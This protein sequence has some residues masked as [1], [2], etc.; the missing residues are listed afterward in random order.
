MVEHA[1][2]LKQQRHD[3]RHQLTAINELAGTDNERLKEY[4]HSLIETIPPSQKSYCDNTAVNAIVS[5]FASICEQSGIE[6]S[7]NLTVPEHNEQ[8]TDS[9]LCVIFGNL[10]E[11]AV[12]A[13]HR[14]T[15]G[16]KFIRLNSSLQYDILTIT[17]DNSFDGRVTEENGKFRSR[18]REDFG[19]GLSSVL[20]VARKGKG[21]ARFESDGLVFLSSVYV[22]I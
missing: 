14:M 20:S 3:L 21:D 5:R 11:N 9:S 4:I 16:H 6:C 1:E 13:C 18:K 22:R 17:M 8:I 12:E 2:K 15:E 19:I 10:L 7:I